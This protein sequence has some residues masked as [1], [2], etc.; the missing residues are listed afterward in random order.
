MKKVICLLLS[1]I[2][3]LLALTA[4]GG[5]EDETSALAQSTDAAPESSDDSGIPEKPD[6]A[7]LVGHYICTGITLAGIEMRGDGVWLTL[8]EGG[9]GVFDDSI[10]EYPIDWSVIYGG[11]TFT[12]P[13]S[14]LVYNGTYENGV[15]K[16]SAPAL[17]GEYTME[18]EQAADSAAAGD[19]AAA[20]VGG[21]PVS[22]GETGSEAEAEPAEI[23]ITSN[24]PEWWDGQW[25]GWYNIHEA[26]GVWKEQEGEAFSCVA[27]IDMRDDLTGTFY[28]W[29]FYEELAAVEIV[30]EPDVGAKGMGFVSA[31]TGEMFGN[32][33]VGSRAFDISPGAEKVDDLI[34]INS[35]VAQTNNPEEYY[36][37][38][39]LVL[40]P[41]GVVWGD[42]GYDPPSAD[43]WYKEMMAEHSSMLEALK[44]ATIGNFGS[45]VFIHPDLPERAYEANAPRDGSA[46]SSG[47]SGLGLAEDGIGSD[48]P[49]NL[50]GPTAEINKFDKF[51]MS[52]P[53]DTF[54]IDEEAIL[55]TV[56]AK[57]GSVDISYILRRSPDDYASE[58]E[59]FD[60]YESYDEYSTEELYIAGYKA[61]RITYYDS[62]EGYNSLVY[63]DFAY[64]GDSTGYF[65]IQI[66]IKSEAGVAST[67]T[68][69]VR[70]ILQTI[71]VEQ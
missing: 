10:G 54:A 28:L 69:E 24:M 51:F 66:G 68:P 6:P 63:I 26:G 29:D 36:V 58:M 38:Y 44:E 18:K 62:W 16:M 53:T 50:A 19:D 64:E 12:S 7:E 70:A 25:Y 45:P 5:G 9:T 41:W 43:A 22:G 11:F 31:V 37:E 46:G 52:Y 55:D 2:L 27:F 3:C 47:G 35:E 71:R 67:W 15:I 56:A 61:R 57:D 1:L 39:E 40:R 60:S 13:D 65:G 17:G 59:F 4:C 20:L 49:V 42:S 30:L 34:W 33:A 8:E 48:D 23:A 21:D 32:F 14:D